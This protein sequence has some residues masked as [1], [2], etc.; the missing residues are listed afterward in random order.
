[1]ESQRHAGATQHARLNP[2]P[3]FHANPHSVCNVQL[4]GSGVLVQLVTYRYGLIP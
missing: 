1:M 2:D 4:G 3:P